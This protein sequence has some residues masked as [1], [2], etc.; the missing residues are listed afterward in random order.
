[1]TTITT[2]PLSLYTLS[3][4]QQSVL[5][6]Y[7]YYNYVSSLTSKHFRLPRE[8]ILRVETLTR[9]QSENTLWN[10]LRLDRQTASS[11]GKTNNTIL[12]NAAMTYGLTQENKVKQNA[13]LIEHIKEHL[14]TV[15]KKKII[16]TVLESGLFL[17]E[18]GLCS[19]S[20][21]AYFITEHDEFI[22]LEIKCPYRYKDVSIIELQNS[23]KSRSM[24][25]SKNRYRIAGTAFSMNVDGNFVFHMEN[26]DPHYRQVQKQMYIMKAPLSMYLVMFGNNSY[27]ATTVRKDEAFHKKE[28]Y[29]EKNVYE[30]YVDKNNSAIHFSSQR[31]RMY[32]FINTETQFST[33]EIERLTRSGLY[34]TFGKL[35]CA[36]CKNAF[37]ASF[38]AN[39]M[40]Q[41]HNCEDHEDNEIIIRAKHKDY[42]DHRKRVISLNKKNADIGMATWGLFYDN[43]N[44]EFKTFCCGLVNTNFTPNHSIDCDY[45]KIINKRKSVIK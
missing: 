39:I 33:E 16:S 14:E 37:D 12:T 13:I 27:I 2:Q 18:F 6:K 32:T 45:A 34:Y 21:D 8:E 26:T 25:K 35:S 29:T 28:L 23:Y 20:P 24:V 38:N 43:D 36:F 15:L 19:A 42:L 17:S 4:E 11:N 30:Q 9:G 3:E 40:L 5:D 22:P 31:K 44:E 7:S 41:Q 1:M 10:L